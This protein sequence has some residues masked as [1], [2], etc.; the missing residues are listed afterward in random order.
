MSIGL[1]YENELAKS[2][3]PLGFEPRSVAQTLFREA[4]GWAIPAELFS[5]L[6]FGCKRKY[7]SKDYII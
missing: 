4:D 1:R 6:G 7:R 2:D 5:D 3:A